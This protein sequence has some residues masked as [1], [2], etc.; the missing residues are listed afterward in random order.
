MDESKISREKVWID[1]WI[2]IASSSSCMRCEVATKWA[3]NCLKE[4]DLR[5]NK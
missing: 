2:A 3:D 1:S 5:F 4:F